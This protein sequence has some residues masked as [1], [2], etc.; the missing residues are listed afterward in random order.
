[1]ST[2]PHDRFAV[3]GSSGFIGRALV[4]RLLSDGA[5]VAAISRRGGIPEDVRITSYLDEAALAAAIGDDCT[6]LFHLA[7][8]AHRRDVDD[9]AFIRANVDTAVAAA[10]VA[11][12]NQ[13]RRFVFVSSIGVIGSESGTKAFTEDTQPRPIA[14]YAQSKWQAEQSLRELLTPTDVELVIVR[15]PLVHG[16]DA[17]G[18]FGRLTKLARQ[19]LLLPFASIRNARS[20]VGIDNLVDFLVTAARHPAAAGQVLLVT[21]HEDISTPA[22]IRRLIV[23]TKSHGH[24]V[25]FPP[26][27][28]ERLASLVGRGDMARQ[29]T[30][31]LSVNATR[32][33]TLLNWKPLVSLDMGLLRAVSAGR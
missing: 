24:L 8:L 29:L 9:D 3:V 14:P 2:R 10:R 7:A 5:Q 33:A 22:L 25:H 31:S 28:L 6:A 15:P 18:N 1:M 17:P 16:P 27:W 11:I 23:H 4:D 13:V 20:L 21:D 32:S 26:E 12:A 30:G 19:P